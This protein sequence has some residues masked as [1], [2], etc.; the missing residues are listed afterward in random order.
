[1]SEIGKKIG[2][3]REDNRIEYRHPSS[4]WNIY[5]I[6]DE[7]LT[8]INFS[9][10]NGRKDC[11]PDHICKLLEKDESEEIWSITERSKDYEV[12]IPSDYKNRYELAQYLTEARL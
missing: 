3:M 2:R 9:P 1:M 12:V 10:R 8:E 11:F 6:E 7:N 5:H 4:D